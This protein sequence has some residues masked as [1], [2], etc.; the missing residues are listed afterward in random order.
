MDYAFTQTVE[1]YYDL[2]IVDETLEE[3]EGY[4]TAILISLFTDARAA[5]EEVGNALNQRGWWGSITR[6]FDTEVG[7][8]LWL[9]EQSRLTENVKLRIGDTVRRSLRWFVEDDIFEAVQVE[10]DQERTHEIII[11]ISFV[12]ASTTR[13][14]VFRVNNTRL[15]S[16]G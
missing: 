11:R 1:G 14:V 15:R 2:A 12:D 9:F 13:E 3:T 5:L 16:D 4:D 8:K 10:V 6:Y 7:S